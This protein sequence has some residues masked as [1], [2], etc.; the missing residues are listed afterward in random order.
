MRKLGSK[1]LAAS[2]GVQTEAMKAVHDYMY[3]HCVMQLMPVVI[4][5]I[6]DP[7]SHSVFDASIDY[8]GT[9][10]QITK[11]MILHKQLA[12]A[13]GL[14]AVYIVSP[15]VRLET[16]EKGESGRHLLE[17]VQ[18]DY[19]MKGR[20]MEEIMRFSE[21][22]FAEIVLA[23]TRKRKSELALLGRELR[24]LELPFQAFDSRELEKEY[25]KD[26]E[27]AVSEASKMP[28][29]VTSHEREFYDREEPD[30]PFSYRNYDIIY[31]EGFG[32]GLSGAEREWEY[33]RL[34]ERMKR[35]GM[36]LQPYKKY[37]EI[38]RMGRLVPSAGA[39]FGVER[40][41]RYCCGLKHVADV[42]PFAKVPG[43]PLVF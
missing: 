3:R 19:E 39:G 4:S 32:E 9:K 37:L 8:C 23:V 25:G 41:V 28:V 18:V 1:E 26:W 15:N 27:K 20:S 42:A 12:L 38:A 31:P 36:D 7:L 17:F 16:P 30:R 33:E 14:D 6:T 5:P 40:L 11:S 29:W 34:L 13:G 35:K 22:L 43:R 10:L 24:P 2:L 21:K